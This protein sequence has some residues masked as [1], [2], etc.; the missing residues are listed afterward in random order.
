M[1]YNI[2]KQFHISCIPPRSHHQGLRR[3]LFHP[4]YL[5][6]ESLLFQNYVMYIGMLI[7]MI[8]E[9]CGFL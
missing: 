7:W 5:K 1:Y 3:F 9:L 4:P 2:Q 6:A 8:F